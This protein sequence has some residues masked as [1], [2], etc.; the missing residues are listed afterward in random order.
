MERES[1]PIFD[2]TDKLG[3]NGIRRSRKVTRARFTID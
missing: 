1:D 2:A 3:I